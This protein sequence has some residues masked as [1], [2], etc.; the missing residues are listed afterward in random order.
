MTNGISVSYRGS[1]ARIRVWTC[2]TVRPASARLALNVIQAANMWP[3][4]VMNVMQSSSAYS[5]S[6]P[7]DTVIPTTETLSSA[8]SPGAMLVS[9]P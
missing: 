6:T 5:P 4:G 2:T 9:G 1:L 8:T 3:C 7:E